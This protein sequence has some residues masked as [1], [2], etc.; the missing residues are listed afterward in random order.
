M[1]TSKADVRALVDALRAG[2]VGAPPSAALADFARDSSRWG[3]GSLV[4]AARALAQTEDVAKVAALVV[5]R[6]ESL[7]G[8]IDEHGA[9]SEFADDRAFIKKAITAWRKRASGQSSRVDQVLLQ[10]N[11]E[12]SL[13][14]EVEFL[15]LPTREARVWA[16]LRKAKRLVS[17]IPAK[18]IAPWFAELVAAFIAYEIQHI[19]NSKW[20]ASFSSKL[21]D[22]PSLLAALERLGMPTIFAPRAV[23]WATI[24]ALVHS[25]APTTRALAAL[26]VAPAS[27][28]DQALVHSLRRRFA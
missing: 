27:T 13:V 9:K 28:A 22:V 4:D 3:P 19:A 7:L 18:P 24:A 8:D 25:H 15:D 2:E 21:T 5:Q 17:A 6:L 10:K 1:T 11:L 26:K 16:A 23:R 14:V 12:E 20:K